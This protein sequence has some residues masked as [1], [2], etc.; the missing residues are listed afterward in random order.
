MLLVGGGGAGAS[1]IEILDPD[2][3]GSTLM[4]SALVLGVDDLAAA[5]L[6]GG[7]VLIVGGQ[8][9]ATGD[10]TDLTY[11]YDPAADDLSLAPPPPDRADGI[12][13][14]QLVTMGRFAL[15]FG[16]EQQVN[17]VDTELDYAA[18]YDGAAGD[19]VYAAAMNGPHDDFAAAILPGGRV[20][21]VAGGIPFQNQELPSDRAEVF[22]AATTRP[23]DIDGDGAV[24]FN[25]L[26][27]I[28]DAWGP[29]P[30]E[31]DCPADLDFSG[32]VDFNDLLAVLDAW[33]P[34]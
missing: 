16:G 28:L 4:A 26:L 19:W 34:C 5:R 30:P 21:L 1:A 22:A 25:D 9:I 8:A 23:A 31:G 3:G 2:T 15:V 32:E 6:E 29:C 27:R 7:A 17:G 20:L 24:T 10:T 18:A 33:G 11:L 13:D 14:H 12:S